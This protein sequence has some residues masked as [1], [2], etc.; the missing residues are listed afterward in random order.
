MLECL[1]T[2]KSVVPELRTQFPSLARRSPDGTQPAIYLDGP[3]GSQVPQVVIDAVSNYYLNHNANSGGKF[4]SSVETTQ[5]LTEAHRAAADW[6]GASDWRECIFGANMTT[7]TMAFSRALSKTW[8]AGER[9][10][11]TELDH[12]GNVTPWKLAAADARVE[13]ATVRV[14]PNDATLDM[15]DF[16]RQVTPGTRLVALTC[17]SNSVGSKPPIQ[18][19]IEVAHAAGAEVYLDAVH[20]APHGLIDVQS[21]NADYCV[22]SAY[23]FFG[24]HVGLLWGRLERLEAL[25]A[26]KL[27]PAPAHPPGKWMTGTQNF[28][29]I[30]G[31]VAAIDY[32]AHIGRR[33]SSPSDA[34]L[35]RREYLRQAFTAI[36]LYERE[37]LAQLISRLSQIPQVRIFGITDELRFAERVPTIALALQGWTS[38]EVA[39]ALGQLGIYCWHGDYYAVDVCRALGQADAGMVRLG[40][41]HTTTQAEIERTVQAIAA[42]VV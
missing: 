26:Y 20:Y 39:T 2:L 5:M 21:W 38:A 14:N 13:V 1:P 19:L 24:P 4:P 41:L 11:V 37:L 36:E 31:V 23:K 16:R 18:E 42:L 33:L 12:D 40:I 29:A 7:L 30:A 17:A 8:R 22:C 15:D 34:C 28:A 6:F 32:I 9:I 25:A 3:A 10:V 27:R 35:S